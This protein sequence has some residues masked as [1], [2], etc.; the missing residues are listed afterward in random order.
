MIAG[1]DGLAVFAGNVV[2]DV[3]DVTGVTDVMNAIV[4]GRIHFLPMDMFVDQIESPNQ[5][6]HLIQTGFFRWFVD[7][8]DDHRLLLL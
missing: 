6:F 2:I 1:V 3:I 4:R 5:V 8:D 7:A